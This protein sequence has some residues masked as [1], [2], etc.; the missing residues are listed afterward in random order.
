MRAIRGRRRWR[1]SIQLRSDHDGAAA[2]HAVRS[3]AGEE[4]ALAGELAA[5]SGGVRADGAQHVI[6]AR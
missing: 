3:R 6:A 2:R 5:V 1:S 4:D